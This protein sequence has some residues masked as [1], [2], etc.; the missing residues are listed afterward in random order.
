MGRRL[1]RL[2]RRPG[3]RQRKPNICMILS[4]ACL[5]ARL[6]SMVCIFLGYTLSVSLWLSSH[7]ETSLF[8]HGFCSFCI[9]PR[10]AETAVS[11]AASTCC[12]PCCLCRKRLFHLWVPSCPLSVF[13]LA[14][15]CFTLDPIC[16]AY[17]PCLFHLGPLSASFGPFLFHSCPC[18]FHLGPL[19]VSPW[20][21][22]CFILGT[23]LRPPSASPCPLSVSWPLLILLFRVCFILC[24]SLVSLSVPP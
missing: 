12:P 14:P 5:T 2:S 20:A 13:K 24:C 1:S 17:A 19:S 15:V 9:Q 4:S 8:H 21:R 7:L 6:F 23:V 16:F 22:V 18:L 10:F 3:G 11:W